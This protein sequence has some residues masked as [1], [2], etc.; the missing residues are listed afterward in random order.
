MLPIVG[1]IALE[2]LLVVFPQG[3]VPGPVEGFL[4]GVG[5]LPGQAVVVGEQAAGDMAQGDDAGAGEG[6][7]VDD[8]VRLETLGIGQGIAQDEAALG[9]GC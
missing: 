1:E 7:H 5:Q 8:G 4:A 3:Q 6:G 2:Q 9:V